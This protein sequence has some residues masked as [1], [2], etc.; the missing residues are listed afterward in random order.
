MASMRKRSSRGMAMRARSDTAKG[1]RRAADPPITVPP[2]RV[3]SAADRTPRVVDSRPA[4]G[5]D[6]RGK[7]V[8]CIIRSSTSLRFGPIGIGLEPTDVHTVHYN[9]IAAVVSDTPEEVLDATREN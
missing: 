3:G 9:D 7:Y 4:R 8:Y 6:S 2:A 1:R 5:P